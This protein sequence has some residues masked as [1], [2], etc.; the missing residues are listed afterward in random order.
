[1]LYEVITEV[2]GQ[3][4]EHLL[5]ELAIAVGQLDSQLQVENLLV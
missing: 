1:M 3:P 2:T 4:C 5:G